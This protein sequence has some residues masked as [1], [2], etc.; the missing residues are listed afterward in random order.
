MWDGDVANGN[1]PAIGQEFSPFTLSLP[2]LATC[3]NCHYLEM[4]RVRS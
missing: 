3:D 1:D 2:P 4:T